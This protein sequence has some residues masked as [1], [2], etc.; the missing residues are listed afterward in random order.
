MMSPLVTGLVA[1][2]ALCRALSSWQGSRHDSESVEVPLQSVI[3][4][5]HNRNIVNRMHSMSIQGASSSAVRI[6]AHVILDHPEQS[7]CLRHQFRWIR[8]GR[9][10]GRHREV[11]RSRRW[12]GSVSKR[13][14]ADVENARTVRTLPRRISCKRRPCRNDRTCGVDGPILG[15]RENVFDEQTLKIS[16]VRGP[17]PCETRCGRQRQRAR[18]CSIRTTDSLS[19]SYSRRGPEDTAPGF[20]R[21]NET[22]MENVAARRRVILRKPLRQLSFSEHC[23]Q[24]NQQIIDSHSIPPMLR[25][26]A[27]DQRD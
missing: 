23:H 2:S 21:S 14:C 8:A 22:I 27:R 4:I 18:S 26:Q 17:S 5:E 16:A 20:S 12:C 25:L 1:L 24:A 13:R 6:V 3:S 11:V 15:V 7:A 10:G 9:A 19:A